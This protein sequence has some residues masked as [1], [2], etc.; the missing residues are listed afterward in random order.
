MRKIELFCPSFRTQVICKIASNIIAHMTYNYYGE[1]GCAYSQ[2]LNEY[3]CFNGTWV[4][5]V[6]E[7]GYLPIDQV[8][9]YL[10]SDAGY[11]RYF[12]HNFFKQT[13]I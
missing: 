6:Y 3:Y 1:N 12:P 8:Y 10:D 5:F 9:C 11:K 13:K 7:H 2:N 4:M